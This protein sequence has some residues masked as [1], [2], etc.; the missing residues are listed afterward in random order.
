MGKDLRT[1]LDQVREAQDSGH[2]QESGLVE[3]GRPVK[4]YLDVPILQQKLAHQGRYPLISCPRVEGYRLPLISNLYGS[5]ELHGLAL[6]LS[7]DRWTERDLFWEY[8]KRLEERK[9]TRVV[10]AS[11]APVKE[12][13]LKGD[14][15]DLG[16]FPVNQHAI[17]QAGRYITPGC[18]VSRDPDTGIQNVGVYRHQVKGKDL[19]GVMINPVH[20]ANPIAH[21]YA[22]L[23]KPMEVA[24]VLGHH[25]AVGIASCVRG[26]RRNFSELEVAGALLGEPLEVVKAETVDLEVPARAEIVIEGVI[27]D[28]RETSTDGPFP[29][30]LHYGRGGKPCFLLRVTAIT[31]R[32]DAIFHDLDPSHREHSMMGG[33]LN[34][35][36][37]YNAVR[38]AMPD[39]EILEA[40]SFMGALWIKLRKRVM[41]EGKRACLAAMAA[42]EHP[43]FIVAVDDDIDLYSTHDLGL[44]LSTRVIA[45]RGIDIIPYITGAH[46]NPTAYNESRDPIIEGGPMTT[47]VIIDATRPLGRPWSTRI[48]PQNAFEE[49]WASTTLEDFAL[50]WPTRVALRERRQRAG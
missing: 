12:V 25:P 27:D 24:I 20:D 49:R 44:A 11:Q 45:D 15:I 7:P 23:G 17:P 9:P 36:R 42:E 10:P 41:G 43:Q 19:L 34:T 4:P 30:R 8:R 1:F 5:W 37:A 28:P 2:F 14:Q 46:L 22:E 21:R 16:L 38:A 32:H 13:V 3:V 31:M 47:R 6:G 40:R 35:V 39:S 33:N 50:T 48:T 29:E 26:S 18:M